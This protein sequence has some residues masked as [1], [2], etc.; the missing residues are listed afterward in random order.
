MPF[1]RLIGIGGRA[2][3]HSFALPRRPIQLAC[4]DVGDI[5]FDENHGRELV[6]GI[7]F[8]LGVIATGEAV[9]AAMRAAAV[10]IQRPAERHAA[11]AIERRPARH[12]LIARIVGTAVGVS[13]R[14][15]AAGFHR[16]GDFAGR[17]FPDTE[18]EERHAVSYALSSPDVTAPLYI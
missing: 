12:L 1:D 4:E 2:D 3:G 14:R 16:H 6:A 18:L 10:R 7:H 5:G 8:E 11:H 17:W 13:E 9:V 15:G